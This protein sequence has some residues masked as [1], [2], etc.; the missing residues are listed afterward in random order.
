L[1]VSLGEWAL[2]VGNWD[3]ARADALY[4]ESVAL[5]RALYETDLG[6]QTYQR[7]LAVG[8][9]TWARLVQDQDAARADALYA[10][11]VALHRALYAAAPDNQTYQRDLAIGLKDWAWLI[12]HADPNRAEVYCRESVHL[13]RALSE[14]VPDNQTYQRDL[15]VGLVEW[16]AHREL[17]GH[18]VSTSYWAEACR[19]WNSLAEERDLQEGEQQYRNLACARTQRIKPTWTR[20]Q[21]FISHSQMD[22]ERALLL[23]HRLELYGIGSWLAP[24]DVRPGADW[25]SEVTRGLETSSML[26]LLLSKRAVESRQIK[27]ELMLARE[28]GLPINVVRLEDINPDKL[29]YL[30][31]DHVWADWLDGEDRVLDDVAGAVAYSLR[32]TPDPERRDH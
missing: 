21:V 7:G 22:H 9:G 30:L 6:N 29:A 17:S 13:R 23:G 18:E 4:A 8:L 25:D 14:R 10:E 27:R 20:K 11:S 31:R 24:R 2:L 26:L 19:L 12:G 5:H 3:G 15:A 1:A 28:L 32:R 16:Q